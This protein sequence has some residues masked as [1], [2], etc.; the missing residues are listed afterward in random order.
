MKISVIA[1]IPLLEKYT[2]LG[3]NYHLVLSHLVDK[4]DEYTK[5]YRKRS[6][7]GDWIMLDNSA[8]EF[9]V[10]EGQTRLLTN[11]DLVGAD[12]VILPDRLFF[13]DDTVLHSTKASK[14]FA[15]EVPHV[16]Q[17]AVPQGRTL[18][19]WTLC[20]QHL[21]QLPISTIGISK[22]YEVWPG[23]LTNLVE[24]V[25][26]FSRT[27]NIHLLGWGREAKQLWRLGRRE[28]LRIR[29]VDSAKPLVYAAALTELEFPWDT[30]NETKY[31]TRPH[32]FFNFGNG[33]IPDEIARKNIEVF[34]AHANGIREA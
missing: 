24:V 33:E 3:D 11:I 8:H 18:D 16:S 1:P 25:R 21:L 12:E 29:G 34:R 20:L 32:G 22:D 9:G 10:G 26:K 7:H 17:F 13:G 28:D 30:L 23:G 5:F 2:S 31:P 14:F 6:A 4:S 19:E 27:V 15:H